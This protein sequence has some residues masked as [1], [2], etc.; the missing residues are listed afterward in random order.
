[1]QQFANRNNG[2][3]TSRPQRN[4]TSQAPSVI[5]LDNNMDI[6]EIQ[7]GADRNS[8][9]QNVTIGAECPDSHAML[10]QMQ[11]CSTFDE[12]QNKC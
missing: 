2:Q 7:Q 8:L 11:K 3:E 9:D 1:M 10:E 6:N 4:S 5:Q 12:L